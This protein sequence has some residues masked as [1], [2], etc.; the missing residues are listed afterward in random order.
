[1]GTSSSDTLIAGA[2]PDRLWGKGGNDSITGGAGYDEFN[3][4]TSPVS[5]QYARIQDFVSGTDKI[6]LSTKIFTSLGTV[7]NGTTATLNSQL[8]EQ[9]IALNSSWSS[10]TRLYFDTSSRYLYYD[11]DGSAGSSGQIQIIAQLVSTSSLLFSDITI[12]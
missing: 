8:F 1:M 2:G 4:D 3:F 10:S 7:S 5:G 9:G 11:S 12:F 6:R